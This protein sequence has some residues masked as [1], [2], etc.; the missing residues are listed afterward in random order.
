MNITVN[1]RTRHYRTVSF[2]SRRN[3]VLLIDQRLLPHQFKI[4]AQAD[5]CAT[6]GAIRDMVV[7]GAGAIGATAAYGLAQ[8]A[9]AFRGDDLQKFTRQIETAF[10][11]LKSAR[12]TAVDP[13]NAMNGV[14]WAMQ[15]GRTVREQQTLALEAAEQFADEDVRHGEAI[16][17]HGARLI[18]QN[19][20]VL[21]HCNAGWLAFVDV[22]A[23]PRRFT[24]PKK[25]A[26]NST[27]FATRRAPAARAPR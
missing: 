7:R 21:T 22:A 3:A 16:G 5:Y 14:R 13:V 17:R 9:R 2:D 8:A 12:P 20:R 4:A 10:Q 1:H 18:R 24:P 19:A 11:T 27:F 23:R 26:A 6:A 25:P 15:A